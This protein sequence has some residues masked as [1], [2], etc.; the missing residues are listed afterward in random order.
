MH[1]GAIAAAII[2]GA[3]EVLDKEKIT[4]AKT[5][6]VLIG[7]MHSVVPGV[8]QD[9]YKILKKE[10]PALARSKLVIEIA[11]VA[12]TCR[13]CGKRTVLEQAAFACASC[14]STDIEITGGRE[15][16]LKE[17]TG[18]EAKVKR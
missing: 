13:A 17:I 9:H 11:P 2:Q 15:M 16:H 5:V 7:R 18:T 10:C 6:I 4:A 14:N 3:L 12:V 1:E 8:L